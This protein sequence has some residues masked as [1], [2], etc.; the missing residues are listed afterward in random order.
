[1]G[2]SMPGFKLTWHIE[3]GSFPDVREFVSR[4]LS[5]SVSTPGLGTVPPPNYDK[6][7]HEYTAVI[8]LPYNVT[9]VIGGNA[10]VVDVDV[11]IP[12][13]Q[14]EAEVELLTAHRQLVYYETS[15]SW[16]DAEA[17]C[18]SKGGHLASFTS[19]DD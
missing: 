9:D 16:S 8:E 14:P 11:T 2:S 3:S 1:M 6:E 7:R 10:L 17:H 15:L 12:E 4:D 19:S 18:V 13:D 5:G